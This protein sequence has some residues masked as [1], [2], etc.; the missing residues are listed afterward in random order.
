MRSWPMPAL[1]EVQRAFGASMLSE[2]DGGVGRY[3]VEEGFSAAERLRIYRNTCRSVLT[4]TLRITYPAVE[5]L[6][7]HDF[8]DMAADRFIVACPAGSAYL[9]DYGGGVC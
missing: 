5:R 2:N 3:I 7:G 6:V 4:E 9:N 8:F 1:L